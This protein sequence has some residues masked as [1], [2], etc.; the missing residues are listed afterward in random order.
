V[1][2]RP[3]EKRKI[4]KQQLLKPPL[5]PHGSKYHQPDNCKKNK[6]THNLMNALQ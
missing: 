5:L 4:V 1:A 3:K 2:E 6:T